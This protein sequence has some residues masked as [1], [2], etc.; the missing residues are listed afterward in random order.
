MNLKDAITQLCKDNGK[1]KRWLAAQMGYGNPS[2]ISNM[3]ARGNVT[4]NTLT[5]ICVLFDYE[6]SIQP[7]RRSG[8]RPS[9]QIVLNGKENDGD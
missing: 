1:T 9:G 4:L 2:A 5:K 6:V 7:R 8:Q 3:L